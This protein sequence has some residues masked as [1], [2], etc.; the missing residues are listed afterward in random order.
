LHLLSRRDNHH[1]AATAKMA[2][3][4]LAAFP[5]RLSRYKSLE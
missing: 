4:I 3:L 5:S 2:F 1:P